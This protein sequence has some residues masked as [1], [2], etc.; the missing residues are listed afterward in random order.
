M[1]AKKQDQVLVACP[2][3]GHR[4]TEPRSAYSS[5]C[6]KCGQHLRVQDILNPAP[7][8]PRRAPK[9]RRVTCFECGA[10]LEAPASAESTMCKQCSR[11]VDLHDYRITSAIAKNFKTKGVLAVEPKG[12]VFNT[13]SIVGDAV[14]RGKF[15]GK[16]AA[17]RSLTIYSTADIKGSLTATHLIIPAENHFRWPDLLKVGSAEIAGEL[18]ANLRARDAVVLRSTARLFGDVDARHLMVED[19]AVVVGKMQIGPRTGNEPSSVL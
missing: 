12:C 14:I 18:A 6:K 16:L 11:Y 4:Q 10:E 1:P 8:A 2:H 5:I 15:H 3:C 7:A 19:G 9:Q 17:E 13:E